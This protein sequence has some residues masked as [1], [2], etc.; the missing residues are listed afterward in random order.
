MK[1]I[2]FGQGF[3]Y[4]LDDR[5]GFWIN[6]YPSDPMSATITQ[7]ELAHILEFH[8]ERGKETV[9]KVQDRVKEMEELVI[10]LRS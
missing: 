3:W 4:V 1:E 9:I 10:K 5:S 6:Q 8:I 2:K 7:G